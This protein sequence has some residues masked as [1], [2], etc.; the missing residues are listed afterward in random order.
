MLSER[1]W[2][3]EWQRS[4]SVDKAFNHRYCRGDSPGHLWRQAPRDAG[5]IRGLHR[6]DHNILWKTL[7]VELFPER[8]NCRKI[9]IVAYPKVCG[10]GYVFAAQLVHRSGWCTCQNGV[11]DDESIEASYPVEQTDAG[12]A[13]F[14]DLDVTFMNS[15]LERSHYVESYSVISPNVRP[16]ADY[17]SPQPDLLERR[18][19]T[20]PSR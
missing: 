8:Q 14:D 2:E 15:T 18:C 9:R 5:Y 7:A 13:Q 4:C 19:T 10:S 6:N 3:R 1:P 20:A 17:D 16:D 12:R 11:N